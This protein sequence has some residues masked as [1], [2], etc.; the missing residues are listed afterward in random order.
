MDLSKAFNAMPHDILL[1]KLEAY[2]MSKN[3][4]CLVASY[5]R[6]MKQ[7]VKINGTELQT[8]T[9]GVPQGSILG[10]ILFNIFM[11]DLVFFTQNCSL[12]NYVDDNT[13][14][15]SNRHLNV[16]ISHLQSDAEVSLNWQ[17]LISSSLW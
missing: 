16:V 5:L 12:T 7:R 2:G 13:T 15:T 11:N 6:N 1:T 4:V 3:T 17:T 10:P 8:I 14:N 9:K